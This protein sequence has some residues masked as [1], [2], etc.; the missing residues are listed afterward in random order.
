MIRLASILLALFMLFGDSVAKY[1][2]RSVSLDYIIIGSTRKV[3]GDVFSSNETIQWINESQV[4]RVIDMD[5]EEEFIMSQ[6]IL[7]VADRHTNADYRGLVS[8]LSTDL[9]R[10]ASDRNKG[11]YYYFTYS[12]GAGE[13]Q[14]RV[15]K[16]MF[17]NE[18]PRK[19]ALYYYN[20]ETRSPEFLTDDFRRFVDDLI[21]TD[22]LV[23]RHIS[24]VDYYEGEYD[25]MK[26]DYMLMMHTY[27][28]EDHRNIV[29]AYE[30]IKMFITLKY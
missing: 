16:D 23:K 18:Y 2:I 14:V 27:V 19:L 3:K 5:T 21:I 8:S 15:V 12:D 22:Q 29:C 11:G 17:L 4:M 20:P 26:N 13:A 30:D 9:G 25:T 24:G 1:K 28:D 6:K 10:K 7:D